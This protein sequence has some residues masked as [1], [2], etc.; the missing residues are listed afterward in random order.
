MPPAYPY[1]HVS[2]LKRSSIASER[3]YTHIHK[4]PLTTFDNSFN[5]PD[6]SMDSL[7]NFQHYSYYD[8]NLQAKQKHSNDS[9]AVSEAQLYNSCYTSPYPLYALD[10]SLSGKDPSTAKIALSS[11]RDGSTNKLEIL[12]GHQTPNV[13][14]NTD[15]STSA[16]TN[17]NS[18]TSTKANFN[19][20]TNQNLNRSKN[21]ISN[22]DVDYKFSKAYEQS[23]KYPIT[24]LQWDPSMSSSSCSP[25]LLATT[26]ECLRIYEITDNN[27]L[28]EKSALT[29]S[30]ILDMNQLPP[31]TS[32][33]WNRYDPHY[34]LTC[35]IDTT[36]TA[37]NLVKETFVAKSQ[38]I[39]HDSEVYDVK[40]ISGDTN[41]FASCSSD[42]SVRLFDLRNLE[43]STIIYEN[44]DSTSKLLSSPTNTNGRSLLRLST[45]NYNANQIAVIEQDS[46]TISVLDVRN[47]G[48]PV[49]RLSH[50][51]APVNSISWH[52]T[53]NQLLSGSD[54]C[55]VFIY[56]FHKGSVV[57]N[58]KQTNKSLLPSYRFQTDLEVNYVCW[59]PTGDWVG[60]NNGKHFQACK[61]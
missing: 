32:F 55:Q 13:N 58:Y 61:V 59:N 35:S 15:S 24:K 53:R 46:N 9:F 14:K 28:L 47:V 4:H 44:T 36:C 50:H 19:E 6:S 5:S 42:G 29:N 23:V 41:V 20:D 51:S 48:T 38:L 31:M 27:E 1:P 56:D 54:D 16:N 17:T 60:I 37:W 52:P 11:Y 39:A 22:A 57:D 30:K 33:D 12:Y 8:E 18:K 25:Q 45:S 43:Q 26:S 10:W 40:Y 7:S 21:E 2:A 3:P 49:Y 34:L